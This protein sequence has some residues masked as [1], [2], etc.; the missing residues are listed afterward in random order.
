M[1]VR[2]D[3]L[4]VSPF[5]DLHG[6]NPAIPW[7][8]EGDISKREA[9]ADRERVKEILAIREQLDIRLRRA[10]EIQK[11]YYDKKY[12]SIQYQSGDLIILSSRNITI[13]RSSKKLDTKFL[14]LFKIIETKCK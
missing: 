4:G 8:V 6:Y 11:K 5:I 1:R 12:K 14:K 13:K 3:I 7:D 10:R 2:H 9:P